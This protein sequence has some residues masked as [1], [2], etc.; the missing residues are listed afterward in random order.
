VK[1]LL[2]Q[3]IKLMNEDA[4]V[5]MTAYGADSERLE[6]ELQRMIAKQ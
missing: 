3:G 4:M 1:P 6:T 5:Q 2:D